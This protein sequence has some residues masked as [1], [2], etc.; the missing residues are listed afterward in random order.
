MY[1]ISDILHS[2]TCGVRGTKRSEEQYLKRVGRIVS[3]SF[4]WLTDVGKPGIFEY[5]YDS[6]G[7]R[8]EGYLKTSVVIRVQKTPDEHI[9]E[10]ENS[11]FILKRMKED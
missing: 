5:V 2:G 6:D 11:I 8:Y 10:T 3:N 7:S 1:I 4:T 9:I